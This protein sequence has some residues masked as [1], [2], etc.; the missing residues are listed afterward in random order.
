MA[1]NKYGKGKNQAKVL[2]DVRVVVLI[3]ELIYHFD[4]YKVRSWRMSS[5]PLPGMF[6]KTN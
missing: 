3:R 2:K 4:P 1:N 6:I 5:D